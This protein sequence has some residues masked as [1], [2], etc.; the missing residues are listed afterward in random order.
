MTEGS[1]DVF[2]V[3]NGRGHIPVTQALAEQGVRVCLF[4]LTTAIP[5]TKASGLP[6]FSYADL[7]Q[8]RDPRA[9]GYGRKIAALMLPNAAIPLALTESCLGVNMVDLVMQYSAEQADQLFEAE[10]RAAFF[11]INTMRALLQSLKPGAVVATNSTRSEKAAISA[12]RALGIPSICIVALFALQ[13][14]GWLAS[15]EYANT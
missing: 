9:Q 13:A 7:P 10:A 14:V 11:P 6:W 8:A 15:E 5:H 3:A 12:A 4:A 2:F 1:V